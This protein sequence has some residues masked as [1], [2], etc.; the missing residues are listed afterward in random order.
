MDTRVL[1]VAHPGS[2]YSTSEGFL[3]RMTPEEAVIS[4]GKNSYGHP[5]PEVVER[6]ERRGVRVFRTDTDGS[7]IYKCSIAPNTSCVVVRPK[8]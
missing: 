2:K 8:L 6:L 4:V 1:K 5:A 7:V 3:V